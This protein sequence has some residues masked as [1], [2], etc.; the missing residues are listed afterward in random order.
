MR[1]REKVLLYL[2][3]ISNNLSVNM[4]HEI[5]Y[6][7]SKELS[8]K[9]FYYFYSKNNIPHSSRLQH[10]IEYYISI[11]QITSNLIMN[12][13]KA[14]ILPKK[15]EIKIKEILSKFQDQNTRLSYIHTLMPLSINN[16][17]LQ[18]YIGFIGYEQKDIDYFLS[19]LLQ[20]KCKFLIDVRYNPISMNT[21][22]SKDQLVRYL[23]DVNIEYIHIKELGIPSELRNKLKTSQN[24]HDD[25]KQLFEYYEQ[26]IF[27][28]NCSLIE[29]I[30]DK[31][32]IIFMCFEQNI[33]ECHRQIIEKY[34]KQKKVH[35]IRF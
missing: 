29:N 15:F 4:I 32:N 18:K 16:N 24:I 22:Y 26:N 13:Q 11:N 17:L 10:D 21:D 14:F 28:P 6:I 8:I 23:K 2:I 9:H 34:I 35:T 30:I 5:M 1:N 33:T 31:E 7:I 27:L 19:I 25:K 12:Q 3:D 20:N